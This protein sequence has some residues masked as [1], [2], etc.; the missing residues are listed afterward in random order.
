MHYWISECATWKCT[1][2]AQIHAIIWQIIYKEKL[3]IHVCMCM[4]ATTCTVH[5]ETKCLWK[6]PTTPTVEPNIRGSNRSNLRDT[7]HLFHF[8]NLAL[9][10]KDSR[11]GVGW[12]IE[13]VTLLANYNRK[14][15]YTYIYIFYISIYIIYIYI[16]SHHSG[17]RI[18]TRE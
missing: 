3:L 9:K 12:V 18:S 5:V 7:Q 14:Y 16:I 17:I 10:L 15:I 8:D 6:P 4:Y 1:V 11:L 13:G 2:G